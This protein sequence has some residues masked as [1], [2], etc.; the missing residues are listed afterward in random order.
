MRSRRSPIRSI[1]I[2]GRG[3][4]LHGKG[5]VEQPI[6]ETEHRLGWSDPEWDQLA[7]EQWYYVRIIQRDDEMAWT[8]PMWITKR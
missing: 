1:E 8:S 7:G 3:K 5:S 4:V 6:D 2:L